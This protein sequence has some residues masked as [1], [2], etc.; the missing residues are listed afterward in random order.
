MPPA[1]AVTH[2]LQQNDRFLILATDGVWAVMTSEEAVQ[3][4]ADVCDSTLQGGTADVAL[5]QPARLDATPGIAQHAMAGSLLDGSVVTRGAWD[6]VASR[7]ASYVA[8]AETAVAAGCDT[9]APLIRM[10]PTKTVA[11]KTNTPPVMH[12][13]ALVHEAPTPAVENILVACA[14]DVPVAGCG[15]GS[16]VPMDLAES[17]LAPDVRTSRLQRRR[18]I[19]LAASEALV[20]AARRRWRTA[21]AG[22]GAGSCLV[23]GRA[24]VFAGDTVVQHPHDDISALVILFEQ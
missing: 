3:V 11:Q 19:A 1:D 20:A 15:G 23:T 17:L 16:D 21:G 22:G 6:S 24:S 9:L 10:D 2:K 13:H 14:G 8:A 4:V 7:E 12:P 18:K 5:T